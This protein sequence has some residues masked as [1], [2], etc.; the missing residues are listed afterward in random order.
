MDKACGTDKPQRDPSQQGGSNMP[1]SDTSS[2]SLVRDKLDESF[3][4]DPM[5]ADGELE[6]NHDKTPMNDSD[7]VEPIYNHNH[8]HGVHL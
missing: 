5:D 6:V 8:N 3:P 4:D 1:G 2:D 7:W